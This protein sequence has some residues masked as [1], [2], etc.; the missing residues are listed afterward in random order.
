MAAKSAVLVHTANNRM[1][2]NMPAPFAEEGVLHR[3]RGK[4]HRPVI[5][6]IVGAAV[7]TNTVGVAVGAAVN[8]EPAVGYSVGVSVAKLSSTRTHD[9]H[10]RPPHRP[11]GNMR[12]TTDMDRDERGEGGKREERERER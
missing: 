11:E 12:R 5:G 8:M 3:L 2:D 1:L 6:N 4:K 10:G 9:R 7:S